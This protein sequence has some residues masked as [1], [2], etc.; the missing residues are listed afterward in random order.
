MDNTNEYLDLLFKNK[1]FQDLSGKVNQWLTNDGVGGKIGSKVNNF[2]KSGKLPRLSV[3]EMGKLTNPTVVNKALQAGQTAGK[4]AGATG[5]RVLPAVGAGL[6]LYDIKRSYEIAD[7]MEKMN[8]Y[9][10]NSFSKK[11]IDFYRN[12]AR[13]LMGATG[14]GGAIGGVSGAG[15]FSVPLAAVGAGLGNVAGNAG[16][17]L[18]NRYK[19]KEMTK[20]DWEY[21]KKMYSNQQTQQQQPTP[22]QQVKKATTKN[23]SYGGPSQSVEKTI[24]DYYANNDIYQGQPSYSGMIEPQYKGTVSGLPIANIPMADPLADTESSVLPDNGNVKSDEILNRYMAMQQDRNGYINKLKEYVDN[25]DKLREASLRNDIYFRGLA[26]WSGNNSLANLG[27]KYNPIN[28][29]A[30]KL[31]LYKQLADDSMSN[32]RE[33]LQLQGDLKLM[34]Q[35]GIDPSI[36]LSTPKATN[37]MFSLLRA[38][39]QS[40]TRMQIAQLNAQVK[41]L[42]RQARIAIAQGKIDLARELQA[43]K[44][45]ASSKL[46]TLTSIG[47]GADPAMMYKAMNDLGYDAPTY[48]EPQ[49]YSDYMDISQ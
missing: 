13:T 18:F 9:K 36:A 8:S 3:N 45:V 30:Q 6:A 34:E 2:V 22:K 43:K 48:V 11:D 28:L 37:S 47:F 49:Q 31:A 46:A 14:L 41:D 35:M 19:P 33:L 4:T 38:R 5:G 44:E 27:D 32:D 42:D 39:E 23:T 29:E 20:E 15:A 24:M 1:K 21:L 12:K 26:G 7:A 16:Y 40:A 17:G 25:F 10:P